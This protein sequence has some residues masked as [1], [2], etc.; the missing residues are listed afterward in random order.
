MAEG[1]DGRVEVLAEVLAPASVGRHVRERDQPPRVPRGAG[2]QHDGPRRVRHRPVLPRGPRRRDSTSS[3]TAASSFALDRQ[4]TGSTTSTDGEVLPAHGSRAD[5]SPRTTTTSPGASRSSPRRSSCT[6]PER[7]TSAPAA[8]ASPSPGGVGLNCVANDE[9]P[10]RDPVSRALR[11]PERRRSRAR[12]GRGALRL[13]RRA[14][15][16]GAPPSAPRLP[17][18]TAHRDARSSPRSSAAE[19]TAF[20]QERRHRGRVRRAHR[21]RAHHRLGAG[22]RRVRAARARSPQHPRRPAHRRP[23][24]SGSTARSSDASGSGRT[25]RASSPS[26]PTSTSRCSGRARTCCSR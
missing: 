2:G 8:T 21:R 11:D 15:R 26:T 25:R 3:T 7:C 22:R 9:D 23:A 19:N 4:A 24:R 12:R 16:H 5:R 18:P 14:R 17:R 10:P 6:S 13:P 20:T 1:D